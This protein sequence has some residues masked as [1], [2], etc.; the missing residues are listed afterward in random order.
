MG[1]ML[2][3]RWFA[4]RFC[5]IDLIKCRIVF[6]QS[7][8]LRWLLDAWALEHLQISE[9][10]SDVGF[11]CVNCPI[12]GITCSI[13]FYHTYTQTHTALVCE[14]NMCFNECWKLRVILSYKLSTH[15]SKARSFWP[16]FFNFPFY[17]V[18]C[19]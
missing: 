3:I 8:D 13:S 9:W 10:D 2:F 1:W 18:L 5:L 6:A 15:L 7:I 19:W 11:C 12:H 4:G 14:W 16:F 17:S